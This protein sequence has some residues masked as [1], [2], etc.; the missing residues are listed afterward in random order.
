M[1]SFRHVQPPAS[2]AVVV[3][4]DVGLG[5]GGPVGSGRLIVGVSLRYFC[6]IARCIRVAWRLNPWKASGSGALREYGSGH[7][8]LTIADAI[9]ESAPH[10]FKPSLR[11]LFAFRTAHN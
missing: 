2:S 3:V 10:A 1:Q 7:A 9:P 6:L 4:D 5:G 8:R 11:G